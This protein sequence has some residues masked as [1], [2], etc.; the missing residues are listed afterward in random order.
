MASDSMECCGLR[1]W[2]V[3][4]WSAVGVVCDLWHWERPISPQWHDVLSEGIPQ[5]PFL[6]DCAR[7][8][9]TTGHRGPL[10]HQDLPVEAHFPATTQPCH[11][12]L[13]SAQHPTSH[14][15]AISSAPHI[16]LSC[17]QLSTPHHTQLPSRVAEA[18]VGDC[19]GKGSNKRRMQSETLCLGELRASGGWSV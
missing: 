13:P 19:N 10:I 12:Q 9:M 15:A 8:Q 16:T 11:T 4:V 6:L 5:L 7:S 2:P 1:V 3:T 14:S 18:V 17:H